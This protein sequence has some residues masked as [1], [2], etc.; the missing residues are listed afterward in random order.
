MEQP[1]NQ[2]AESGST[3]IGTENEDTLN[4]AMKTDAGKTQGGQSNKTKEFPNTAGDST[5][6]TPTDAED[7]VT[8]LEQSFIVLDSWTNDNDRNSSQERIFGSTSPIRA[9]M[10]TGVHQA[11]N[12]QYQ[13]DLSDKELQ[14]NFV[15]WV[16]MLADQKWG[17][18]AAGDT[19]FEVQ[20]MGFFYGCFSLYQGLIN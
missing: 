19:V 3:E 14:N 5:D 16:D 7:T 12:G 4:Q 10:R 8:D 1:R 15:K 2:T 11:K 6:E 20:I 13:L 17:E 18:F 9:E